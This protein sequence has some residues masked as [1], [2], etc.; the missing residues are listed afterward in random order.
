MG[1]DSSNKP[2][3]SETYYGPTSTIP[4]TYVQSVHLE[5]KP[6]IFDDADYSTTSRTMRSGRRVKAIFCRNTS[7]ITM[8]GGRA[9]TWASG[10]IGRRFDGYSR[11]TA[12]RVAGIIDPYLPATGVRTGDL[13][14]LIVKG[15]CLVR[16]PLAAADFDG[17]T[18]A[19]GDVLYG[20]TAAN[21]TGNSTGATTTNEA[22]FLANW[23]GSAAAITG[24]TTQS[25]GDLPAVM[26]GKVGR[27]ISACTS[28]QSG[29]ATKTLVDLDLPYC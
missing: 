24:T 17:N 23:S 16:P 28:G 4:T 10:Y 15:P 12:C 26:L 19:A 3:L 2:K 18:W 6:G 5:G 20:I 25:T 7:G 11:T 13:C 27:V 22:G 8:F 29:A 14:W 21:S 9:V 1:S